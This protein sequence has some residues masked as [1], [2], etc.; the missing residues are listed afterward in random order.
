MADPITGNADGSEDQK[1]QN[2]DQ[3]EPMDWHTCLAAFLD[4]RWP[5]ADPNTP[6]RCL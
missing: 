1:N 5:Q 6:K 4:V 2:S 3:K